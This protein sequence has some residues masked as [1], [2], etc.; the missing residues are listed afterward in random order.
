M[1]N[2]N[3]Q[4]PLLHQDEDPKSQSVTFEVT[5][6]K[7]GISSNGNGLASDHPADAS[8][9]DE[10]LISPS[11]RRRHSRSGSIV[12]DVMGQLEEVFENF[13]EVVEEVIEEVKD[14][15]AEDIE[16]IKPRE[17]GDHSRKLSALALAVLVFYKVSGG[18]FGC[19][20]SVK[21]AGPFYALMGFTIF[22]LCWCCQEALITAELGSAFPEPSVRTYCLFY[23]NSTVV[24][25]SHV[26]MSLVINLCVFFLCLLSAGRN[27][28]GGRSL[29]E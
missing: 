3:E 21:A 28:L 8:D 12:D 11:G 24:G 1:T 9:I 23:N 25:S 18:P 29:G 22:P 4:T 13:E 5:P 26:F 7:S 10:E 20:P 19:E 16:P 6:S 27:R 15:L 17:E 14:V 2:N